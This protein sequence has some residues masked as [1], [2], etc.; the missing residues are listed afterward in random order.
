MIHTILELRPT[1]IN[2]KCLTLELRPSFTET[3]L[4]ENLPQSVAEGIF[5]SIGIDNIYN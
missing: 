4:L 3:P 5:D 1:T 2:P